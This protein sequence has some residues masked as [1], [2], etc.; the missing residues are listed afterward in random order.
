L[1]KKHNLTFSL[2]KNLEK[3]G[4]EMAHTVV[5]EDYIFATNKAAPID[6]API[7]IGLKVPPLRSIS[8]NLDK[9]KEPVYEEI[10][11]AYARKNNDTPIATPSHKYDH[12]DFAHLNG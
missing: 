9:N 12:L 8:T 10:N 3:E 1:R 5:I 11:D 4:K 6:V 2:K 7:N